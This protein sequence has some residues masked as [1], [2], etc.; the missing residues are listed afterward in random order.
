MNEDET[1]DP[2]DTQFL[3][4]FIGIHN[5]LKRLAD[6]EEAR[7]AEEVAIDEEFSVKEPPL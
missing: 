6:I 4:V 1:T 3:K 2:M 7:R 5:Q